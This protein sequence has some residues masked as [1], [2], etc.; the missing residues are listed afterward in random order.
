MS[1]SERFPPDPILEGSEALG[2]F[3]PQEA[4]QVLA[5]EHDHT[6]EVAWPDTVLTL[7]DLERLL[8]ARDRALILGLA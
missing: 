2:D 5:Y 1:K 7:E 8:P 6:P 3:P 4:L